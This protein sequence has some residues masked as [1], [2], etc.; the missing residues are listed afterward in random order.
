MNTSTYILALVSCLGLIIAAF[1]GLNLPNV[2]KKWIC[3]VAIFLGVVGI[4]Y[5]TVQ[6]IE[7]ANLASSPMLSESTPAE[8]IDENVIS[9]ATE[10]TLPTET[11]L[12]DIIA[13]SETTELTEI[14]P[15][16]DMINPNDT[17]NDGQDLSTPCSWNTISQQYADDALEAYSRWEVG[18]ASESDMDCIV[19][20]I[21]DDPRFLCREMQNA[22]SMW[23]YFYINSNTGHVFT[24]LDDLCDVVCNVIERNIK[25]NNGGQWHITYELDE[26]EDVNNY[27][28]L[29]SQEYK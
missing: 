3:I 25:Y 13:P 15:S 19:G 23:T 11:T 18:L 12:A 8:T 26:Q 9:E 7:H 17:I 14:A 4:G 21:L 6:Y 2:V 10:S 1:V 22:P 27:Y 28:I 24:S 29:L 20:Y 5:T 16:T